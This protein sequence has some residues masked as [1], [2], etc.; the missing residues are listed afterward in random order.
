M[1]KSALGLSVRWD[2]RD[3]VGGQRPGAHGSL[4]EFTAGGPR[5]EGRRICAGSQEVMSKVKVKPG[6]PPKIP[7]GVCHLV[8]F[9]LHS[10]DTPTPE[11]VFC[12]Q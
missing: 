10:G 9:L 3:P 12:L 8:F 1:W 6:A 4:H 11:W 5:Q 2:P 7:K